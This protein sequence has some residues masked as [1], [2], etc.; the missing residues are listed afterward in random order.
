MCNIP[1]SMW[2]YIYGDIEGKSK[3]LNK[4]QRMN[5]VSSRLSRN[6]KDS[7]EDNRVRELRQQIKEEFGEGDSE[8][9]NEQFNIE[10]YDEYLLKRNMDDIFEDIID[11]KNTDKEKDSGIGVSSL[12]HENLVV[13]PRFEGGP[14]PELNYLP[15]VPLSSLDRQKLLNFSENLCWV[16]NVHYLLKDLRREHRERYG[17]CSQEYSSSVW[18]QICRKVKQILLTPIKHVEKFYEFATDDPYHETVIKSLRHFEEV[19]APILDPPSSLQLQLPSTHERHQMSLPSSLI[20]QD[21][22]INM[23]RCMV[24]LEKPVNIVSYREL[25][26]GI[27]FIEFL[28]LKE[29]ILHIQLQREQTVRAYEK[30]GKHMETVIEK[31]GHCYTLSGQSEVFLAASEIKMFSSSFTKYPVFNESIED[32]RV[33]CELEL[34]DNN[35]FKSYV[36]QLK[37]ENEDYIRATRDIEGSRR[38]RV[39]EREEMLLSL[40]KKNVKMVKNRATGYLVNQASENLKL[41]SFMK[42]KLKLKALLEEKLKGIKE[43]NI[44][45]KVVRVYL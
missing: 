9:E 17:F 37:A 28:K 5:S 13:N 4:I 44:E 31:H 38:N 23:L 29:Q 8:E 10:E 40:D 3:V 22:D 14:H 33:F 20:L 26:L 30:L 35:L 25:N 45:E 19:M 11:N 34:N 15:D 36:N 32:F 7:K 21:F 12:G 41:K 18:R 39:I 2:A 27:N 24:K 42:F 6:S 43:L 1:L 16:S